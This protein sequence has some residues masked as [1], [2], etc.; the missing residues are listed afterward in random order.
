MGDKV[1][2]RRG[3][4]N[5]YEILFSGPHLVTNINDSGTIGIQKEVVTNTVNIKRVR[6]KLCAIFS[7]GSYINVEGLNFVSPASAFWS[8][9]FPEG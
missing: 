3:T 7:K 9:T 4:E 2:L 6:K 5:K 1:L 8:T